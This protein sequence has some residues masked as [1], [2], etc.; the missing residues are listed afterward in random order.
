MV[1]DVFE[2]SSHQQLS[3]ALRLHQ[4]LAFSSGRL[5]LGSLGFVDAL[6]RPI[7]GQEEL[8]SLQREDLQAR[9]THCTLSVCICMPD[10]MEACVSHLV[11]SASWTAR[12]ACVL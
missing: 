4:V 7:S 5:R 3:S 12:T 8:Q 9:V 1:E 6:S 10:D 11:C 2:T